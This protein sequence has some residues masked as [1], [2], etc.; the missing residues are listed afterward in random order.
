MKMNSLLH[1][2]SLANSLFPGSNGGGAMGRKSWKGWLSFSQNWASA[3]WLTRCPI[4]LTK[5]LQTSVW[6]WENPKNNMPSR[7]KLRI[8][9]L[10]SLPLC[11][12]QVRSGEAEDY[13]PSSNVE[14]SVHD[15]DQLDV[16]PVPLRGVPSRLVT[17]KHRI[18]SCICGKWRRTRF[19]RKSKGQN[20]I[21]C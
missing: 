19:Q 5:S 4:H 21:T 2:T 17:H 6:V 13:W 7:G 1:G 3:D 8:S 9:F 20:R 11:A 12:K 15:R 14:G 18:L 16:Q 10:F